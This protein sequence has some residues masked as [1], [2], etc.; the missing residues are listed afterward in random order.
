MFKWPWFMSLFLFAGLHDEERSQ[1]EE[2]DGA[3]VHAEAKLHLLLCWWRP[4]WTERRHLSGWKL[5]CGGSQQLSYEKSS[6]YRTKNKR[7]KWWLLLTVETVLQYFVLSADEA[8]GTVSTV[9]KKL[10]HRP[11]VLHFL[12]H[13]MLFMQ[14]N[15]WC[16]LGVAWI[17]VCYELV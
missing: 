11:W 5:Q 8:M 1:E 10:I 12:L 3:L 13:K 14:L 15:I 16:I 7:M 9:V 4:C 2:L 17:F 6:T